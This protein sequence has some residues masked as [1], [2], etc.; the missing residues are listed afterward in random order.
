MTCSAQDLDVC[1]STQPVMTPHSKI[2][3]CVAFASR[4]G[5]CS[6]LLAG[7]NRLNTYSNESFAK[8]AERRRAN[9]PLPF[10]LLRHM[11][12]V[13]RIRGATFT[14][15][16]IQLPFMRLP[17]SRSLTR[18]RRCR[19]TGCARVQC[20]PQGAGERLRTLSPTTAPL[21]AARHSD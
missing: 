13:I 11:A 15:F 9:M 19:A 4:R 14:P 8:A 12:F 1:R 10:A 18:L 2:F 20:A 5:E 3:L 17:T 7:F 6:R 16:D 21:P